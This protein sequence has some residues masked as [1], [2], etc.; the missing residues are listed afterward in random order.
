MHITK[1]EKDGYNIKCL[2][3]LKSQTNNYIIIRILNFDI[4]YIKKD[5]II[6]SITFVHTYAH[7][8]HIENN[9]YKIAD[10]Y[11]YLE[12]FFITIIC[13]KQNNFIPL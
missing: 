4:L 13:N 11:I 8:T 9:I 6:N 7:N 5:T 12:L 3:L 2:K 10:S 1:K